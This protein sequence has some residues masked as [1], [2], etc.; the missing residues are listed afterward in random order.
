MVRV[1]IFEG[2]HDLVCGA[3]FG[4]MDNQHGGKEPVW[5]S[6][7]GSEENNSEELSR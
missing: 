3:A 1:T 2:G 4:F 7:N 5:F 6:G